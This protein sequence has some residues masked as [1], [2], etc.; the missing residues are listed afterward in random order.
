MDKKSIYPHFCEIHCR[1]YHIA[2]TAIFAESGT[3]SNKPDA[4]FTTG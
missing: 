1:F 4:F 2:G 3:D